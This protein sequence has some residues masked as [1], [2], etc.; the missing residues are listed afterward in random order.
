MQWWDDLWLNE[1]FT[2]F[3][4]SF[5]LENINP[6][7]KDVIESPMLNFRATKARGYVDDERPTATH[8][9]RGKVVDTDVAWANFDGIVYGKGA[10]VMKQLMYLIG[11]DNFSKGI[12]K[13]FD[14][15]AWGNATI[16]DLLKDM[17]AFFP[18]GVD[19]EQW[20]VSWL[21][22]PSLDVFE[23]LWD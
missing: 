16:T 11:R 22:T 15:F 3:I 2:N 7:M 9:V 13:Y 10:G 17:E 5:T 23:P 6:L 1:S 4:S 19:V 21:E 18:S 14:R 12:T 20:R 8:A